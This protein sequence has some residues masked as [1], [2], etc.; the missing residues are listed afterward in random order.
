[1]VGYSAESAGL[2]AILSVAHVD[3]TKPFNH[4]LACFFERKSWFFTRVWI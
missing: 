1:M 4:V 3:D 2:P